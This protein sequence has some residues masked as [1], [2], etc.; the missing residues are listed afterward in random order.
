[1]RLTGGSRLRT[2]SIRPLRKGLIEPVLS[3]LPPVSLMGK[4]QRYVAHASMP[5]PA[6]YDNYNLLERLGPEAVFTRD[7]LD[8]VDRALPP[9]RMA[10]AYHAA[11]AQSLINRMLALDLKYTL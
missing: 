10:Q 4:A 1:M 11:H 5:M 7:F 9:A 3:L 6:R 8:A 2:G